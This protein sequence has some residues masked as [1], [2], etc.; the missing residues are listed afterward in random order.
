MEQHAPIY[1]AILARADDDDRHLPSTLIS[2]ILWHSSPLE[3]NSRMEIR[4]ACLLTNNQP[5][6]QFIR[7][8]DL[9]SP[10][11]P[12]DGLVRGEADLP[13]SIVVQENSLSTF[14]ADIG[15][16]KFMRRMQ[17]LHEVEL[18]F[19][20]RGKNLLP[21]VMFIAINSVYSSS[22]AIVFFLR[23][24]GEGRDRLL[25]SIAVSLGA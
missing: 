3:A 15:V 6:F 14:T 22:L 7:S 9:Y 23:S 12:V 18:E 13:D 2:S 19:I 8:L 4:T 1:W 11:V 16:L 17:H 25:E 10:P 5:L 21:F 20:A 24:Q